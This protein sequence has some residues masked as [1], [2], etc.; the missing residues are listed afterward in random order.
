MDITEIQRQAERIAFNE[1]GMSWIEKFVLT[2]E[3]NPLSHTP[4]YSSEKWVSEVHIHMPMTAMSLPGAKEAEALF[5]HALRKKM[6]EI[7]ELALTMGRNANEEARSIIREES[8][9]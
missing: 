8:S 2:P 5:N 1:K 7:I 4:M 9:N 3:D 6:P